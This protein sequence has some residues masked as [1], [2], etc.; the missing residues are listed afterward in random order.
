MQGSHA[1]TASRTHLLPR[2]GIWV[3][4]GINRLYCGLAVAVLVSVLLVI[5]AFDV[6]PLQD[7]GDW[8]YQGYLLNRLLGSVGA[9][10]IIKPWPVPNSISQVLLAMLGVG[11]S[12]IAAA[13][14]L[15]VA[16]LL[17]STVVMA[18]ASRRRD[19]RIDGAKLLLLLCL[20][21]VHA[22]FWT[23]EI[24]YQIGLLLFVTYVLLCQRRREPSARFT[25][26]Y[27]V[28]LFFCHA[29]AL[30]M[31]MVYVG[32]RSLRRRQILQ[33]LFSF[34]PAV[35]LAIW[36]KLADPR[37][38]WDKSR[39]HLASIKDI[40]GYL[41]YQLAKTGPYHNFVFADGGDYERAR[42]LYWLGCATNFGFAACMIIIMLMWIRTS[43]HERRASD[44]LL[45]AFVLLALASFD[46]GAVLGVATLGERLIAPALILAVMSLHRTTLAERIAAALSA[47][48][49]PVFLSF[50]FAGLAGVERGTVPSNDLVSDPARRLQI[51]FWHKPFAFAGLADAAEQSWA[52]G[53]PA[54]LPISFGTSLLMNA[55]AKGECRGCVPAER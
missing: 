24:N 11:L 33:S 53:I 32:W 20:G 46:V 13:K 27:A 45:T 43:W 39:P 10:A 22:P 3:G 48:S 38:D 30:G 26:C 19:G 42:L 21:V 35:G 34:A 17:L 23:G 40:I 9:P 55:Q 36:Y 37:L 50:A 49:I 31:L 8:T 4:T 18:V 28:L 54:T 52:Q 12:P 2:Y 41:S 29:L 44:E 14:T 7:Y 6:P 16:Y 5:F 1:A 51:L 15:I 25:G 47:L